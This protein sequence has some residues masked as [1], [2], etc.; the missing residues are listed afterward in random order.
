MSREMLSYFPE[1]YPE[2]TTYSVLARLRRRLGSLGTS[3]FREVLF[4]SHS[5]PTHPIIPASLQAIAD[6]GPSDVTVDRLRRDHTLFDYFS[7]FR[8]TEMIE[9][10]REET[11]GR[12]KPAARLG[13]ILPLAGDLGRLRFCEKCLLE[14]RQ[15]HGEAYWHREH[16]LSEVLVCAHHETALRRSSL[17]LENT[18]TELICADAACLRG[19]PPIIEDTAEAFIVALRLA[20]LVAKAVQGERFGIDGDNFR[21]SL[22]AVVESY[23]YTKRD[24]RID[25]DGLRHGSRTIHAPLADLWQQVI[26]VH[27]EPIW[28][29]RLVQLGAGLQTFRVLLL[30]DLL[31]QLPRRPSAREAKSSLFEQPPW[32]CRNQLADHYGRAVVTQ[33]SFS[34]WMTGRVIATFECD[35]GHVYTRSCSVD[36]KR[37]RP[38][39]RRIGPLLRPFI[40][41]YI[42]DGS[43]LDD[44]AEAIGL[45][46][47]TLLS[48]LEKEEIPHQWRDIRPPRPSKTKAG[49]KPRRSRTGQQDYRARSEVQIAQKDAELVVLLGEAAPEILSRR[50]EVHLTLKRLAKSIGV[51]N[52][53]RIA[54]Y[55]KTSEQIGKFVETLQEFHLRKLRNLV[56]EQRVEGLSL[57]A[58]ARLLKSRSS[59]KDVAF[60][61][62]GLSAMG[63]QWNES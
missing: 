8:T 17:S 56:H 7:A 39:L 21:A 31:D 50:P 48:Q 12:G 6:A 13:A 14:D 1:I 63:I 26:D 51:K 18:R 43:T 2:E 55:P 58:I 36:G 3:A 9:R 35:C 47:K 38:T 40:E 57:A 54:F 10:A 22:T 62:E 11:I 23:G 4:G 19:S 16:Q 42:D 41:R 5:T 34:P 53:G 59:T 27:G 61:R 33:A 24:L 46:P 30:I 49:R 32:L 52:S 37:T 25:H 44:A 20:K 29:K 28:L 45:L 15:N 60:V